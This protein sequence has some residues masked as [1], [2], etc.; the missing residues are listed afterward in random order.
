MRP[1]YPPT[2][3]GQTPG[4]GRM[5]SV[6][7][8]DSTPAL[9]RKQPRSVSRFVTL[10]F[11]RAYSALSDPSDVG[12]AIALRR[13]LCS[14]IEHASTESAARFA[15]LAAELALRRAHGGGFGR[16]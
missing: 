11:K 15:C 9:P 2:P 3:G 14:A 7:S 8:T 12:P 10:R 1:P 16:P 4:G 6:I 5:N 13:G